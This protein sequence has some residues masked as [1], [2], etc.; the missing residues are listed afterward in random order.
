M[1][2]SNSNTQPRQ[3]SCLFLLE[4]GAREPEKEEMEP[5]PLAI[6]NR[7]LALKKPDELLGWLGAEKNNPAKLIAFIAAVRDNYDKLAAD[8]NTL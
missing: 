6:V 2:R 3:T 5:Y 1:A 8:Y 7:L 4:A